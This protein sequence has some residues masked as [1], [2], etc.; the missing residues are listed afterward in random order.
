VT[1]PTAAPAASVGIDRG[2]APFGAAIR[3]GDDPA[4]SAAARGREL[5]LESDGAHRVGRDPHGAL[6]IDDAKMSREH[7]E[8]VVTCGEIFV[9]DLGS[10][11]GLWLGGARLDRGRKARWPTHRMLLA[12]Q[13]VF[14]LVVPDVHATSPEARAG[15]ED[16]AVSPTP[17]TTSTPPSTAAPL[18]AQQAPLDDEDARSRAEVA[19]A[20]AAPPNGEF[21][22]PWPIAD[23]GGGDAAAS[24]GPVRDVRLR[25]VV[26]LFAATC[27][28]VL[29]GLGFLLLS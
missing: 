12:G 14:A 29:I 25:A 26:L 19:D 5:V 9:R 2:R 27:A 28:V 4:R 10:T 18:P 23:V 16:A 15:S 8:I 1:P 24:A 3:I 6:T 17:T 20:R 21:G 22:M 7:F 11:G 13:S